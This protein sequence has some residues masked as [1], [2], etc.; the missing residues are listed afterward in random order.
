MSERSIFFDE[1]QACLRAH[2]KYVVCAHD[3]ITEPTLRR[4]LLQ[5]GVSEDE[6]LA[7]QDEA[8]AGDEE[9]FDEEI[10]FDAEP[11]PFEVI[12]VI[13]PEPVEEDEPNEPEGDP[14]D[15]SDQPWPPQ[16]PQQ[17]SLF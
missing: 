12:E 3:P 7:L 6:I 8:R 9:C 1:W 10:A 15:E 13:P 17:L 2:Y 4:V 14:G 5:T 11:E 16:G